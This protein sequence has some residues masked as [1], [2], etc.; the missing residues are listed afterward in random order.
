MNMTLNDK[1]DRLGKILTEAGSAV[2]ALSGGADSSFLVHFASGISTLNLMAVTVST[3]YMFESEVS[4][5]AVFCR[6][7]GVRHVVINVEFPASVKGNPPDRCYLCKKEVMKAVRYE[8]DKAGMKF[9]FDGTN[10]DDVSD[11]RPGLKALKESGVRSPLLEA[12]L[13][14]EEIRLLATKEGLEVAGRP[15]NTCLLTR[16]PHD[17]IIT[18]EALRRAEKAETFLKSAGFEGSRVRV[19]GDMVRIE[20]RK[21]QLPDIVN[22][23]TRE[24]I[25]QAFKEL[26][27]RYITV[28]LEG[29]RSGSMNKTAEK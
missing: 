7:R 22:E 21:E 24:K 28:D 10:V 12:G 1:T 2:I 27:Y 6:E 20:C 13:T 8:A 29:Y 17:T 26:G 25:T 19:H 15:S 18:P 5:A 9:I 4:E 23:A 11:F 16:F 14:K 3:P